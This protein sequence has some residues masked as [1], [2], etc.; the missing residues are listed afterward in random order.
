[1][2]K[3]CHYLL[4]NIVALVIDHM[5]LIYLVNKLKILAQ[6]TRW[7]LLFLEF[8]FKLFINQVDPTMQLMHY[9]NSQMMQNQYV[10]LS[11]KSWYIVCF[12]T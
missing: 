3:F 9:P 8:N 4:S 1:M 12:T 6:I 2:H 10:Y 5:V 11:N 7:L